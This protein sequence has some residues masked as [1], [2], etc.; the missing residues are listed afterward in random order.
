M[1][2]VHNGCWLLDSE[3]K[4]ARSTS[5]SSAIWNGDKNHGSRVFSQINVHQHLQSNNTASWEAGTRLCLQWSTDLLKL[6][7][8]NDIVA[9]TLE[10]LALTLIIWYRTLELHSK[11]YSLQDEWHRAEKECEKTINTDNAHPRVYNKM[12]ENNCKPNKRVMPLSDYTDN[13]IMLSA[14]P[15]GCNCD[16]FIVTG[17]RNDQAVV[18]LV[19]VS[20]G[21]CSPHLPLPLA[22]NHNL[23][24][25]KQKISHVSFDSGKLM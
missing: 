12:K 10:A 4:P 1:L 24:M 13:K 19:E 21:V 11:Q 15:Y 18:S 2:Q 3:A 20:Q 14:M 17:I 9:G 25:H 22:L 16:S 6:W 5:S 8:Q 23:H 7:F